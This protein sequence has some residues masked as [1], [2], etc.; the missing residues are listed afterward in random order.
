MW[1]SDSKF[2]QEQ[3]IGSENYPSEKHMV[4]TSDGYMLSVY[5]IPN[6]NATKSNGKVALLMPR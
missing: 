3:L 2:L 1:F 5:R 6:T 4:R